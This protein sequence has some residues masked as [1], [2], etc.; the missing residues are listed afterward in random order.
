MKKSKFIALGAAAALLAAAAVGGTMAY[1]T[2]EKSAENIF[3]VGNV[4]IDLDESNG[5]G[6]VDEAYQEWL[7]KQKLVPA[8]DA[9]QQIAKEITIK[10]VGTS[11]AYLW[12]EIW[13]P[14]QLDAAED[15]E[16]SLHLV[17]ENSLVEISGTYLQ[18]K[19]IDGVTYNGYVYYY[20]NAEGNPLAPGEQTEKLLDAVY[21]DPAVSQCPEAT[22]GELCLILKDGSEYRGSW[23]LKV[24]AVGFQ[25]DGFADVTDALKAYYNQ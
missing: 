7:A 16:R 4:R 13:I 18:P 14:A 6:A 12:A 2:D 9:A 23:D 20:K 8:K 19:D 3:T 24:N 21:M 5:D 15:A 25:A 11:P 17:T 22:P 10:N 1:F